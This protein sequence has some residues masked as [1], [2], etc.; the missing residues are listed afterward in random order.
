MPRNSKNS[1]DEMEFRPKGGMGAD[2]S[3]EI[4]SNSQNI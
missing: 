2:Y 1:D 3:S 4:K